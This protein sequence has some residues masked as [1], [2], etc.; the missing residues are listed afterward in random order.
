MEAVNTAGNYTGNSVQLTITNLN[1][2]DSLD[3]KVDLGMIL[4][5]DDASYQPMVLAGT[6]TVAVAPGKKGDVTVTVFCGNS[7]KHCPAKGARF[8]Y[9]K[10]G[11]D[12]LLT[13]L[14]FINEHTLF[15]HLGQYAV[16]AVTNAH[17]LTGIYDPQRDSLSKRLIAVVSAATGR[18]K[19]DYYALKANVETPGQAAYNPKTL[20]IIVQ[21]D[22]ALRSPGI[23]SVGVYDK[24]DRLI[25]KII[26]RRMFVAGKHQLDVTFDA[27]TYGAGKYTIRLMD[28]ERVLQEKKVEAEE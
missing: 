26:D 6:E 24:R 8:S 3:L 4:K 1:K 9:W 23:L 16:W 22:V 18:P 14:R 19:P 2:K 11:S 25:E 12:T 27:E 21:F 15:D 28:P 13:V 17:P 20:K 10:T 7:P 5:P